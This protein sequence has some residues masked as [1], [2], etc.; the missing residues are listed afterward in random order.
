MKVAVIPARGGSKRI[1]KKNIRDFCGKPALAYAIEAA[2]R[3]RL[4]DKIIVSS[5]DQSIVSVANN[6]GAETPFMRP[7]EL[8]DDYSGTVPVIA[9][10]IEEMQ[11][12]GVTPDLVCCIYPCVPL[13]QYQDL[14]RGLQLLNRSSNSKFSFPVAE[15]PSSI[16]RA[17]SLDEKALTEPFY[18]DY[19]L[20][21]SQDCMPAF[22]DAG[23]FY[24]GYREDWIN[25]PTIH[26]CGV[27]LVIPSW[28]AV[29][30]DTPDDWLRA[31]I[32]YRLILENQISTK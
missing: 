15:F 14:C 18:P 32:A 27:G 22:Y 2:R 20:T 25:S 28:R 6:F 8:A 7:R 5:D 16:Q 26:S 11:T 24:W 29:D 1:P 23:Q 13:I 19:Q 3:S 9:H 31:E 4:F 10:A 12:A 30:I 17:I 21:R